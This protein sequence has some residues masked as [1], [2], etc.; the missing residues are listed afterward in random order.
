[1]NFIQ[2]GFRWAAEA[3]G[4][5]PSDPMDPRFW[6]GNS[7]GVTNAGEWVGPD[8]AFQLDVVQSVLGRLSG[9]VSTLP[10]MVF[11]RIAIAAPAADDDADD[12]VEEDDDPDGRRPAR[13]HPLFR[14]LHKQPNP[15]QTSQEFRAELV[16]H[17]AFWRN[18]YSRI[19]SDLDGAVGSLEPIHPSRMVDIK[20]RD[21]RVFYKFTVPGSAEYLTLR[22]D[23]IWHIRM[24]P[25]TTDGLRGQYMWETSRETFGRAL[26][27]EK[28]G[29]LY[30]R[31]GGGGGGILEHPGTFKSKEDQQNFLE[32]WRSGGS[33]LNRHS[34]RLLL[35]GV[36]YTRQTVNNDEA[37]FLETLKEVS[38]KLCRLW[39]MPPHM[40]GILD[41]AT[42]SNIEQQST[43]YVVYTLA[44]Y[45]EAIEQSAERDL[46]IGPDQDRYFVEH[47]VDG[48]LRG[49]WKTRWAGYAQGRQWGWLSVNDIRRLENMPPIDGGDSYLVPTN[50]VPADQIPPPA[51]DAPADP[52]PPPAP[53]AAAPKP[54]PPS[55][56]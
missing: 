27:V 20:E 18:A 49:D 21:G 54:K 26:A 52:T 36:K 32:A 15:R 10:L 40:V 22:D 12:G 8:Q 50:M 6:G 28:F 29:S 7:S 14:L 23:Q 37:Q 4:A 16:I 2:R 11:E 30:F 39:N 31:N 17:L 1:M 53:P 9:T 44:P 24:A 33:G 43:E 56:K 46:L 19:V 34:D 45:L 42:F 51:D 13:E 25:L 47:N 48:L 41:R 35:Q 55:R 38:V 5:I 3:A